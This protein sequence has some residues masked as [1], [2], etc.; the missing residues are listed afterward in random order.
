MTYLL[1]YINNF[2][3]RMLGPE[4]LHSWY[5]PLHLTFQLVEVPE[6]ITTY[7][8]CLSKVLNLFRQYIHLL[9]IIFGLCKAFLGCFRLWNTVT[10]CCLNNSF[11]NASVN[12]TFSSQLINQSTLHLSTPELPSKLPTQPTVS[13]PA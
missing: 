11:P 9:I 10:Q 3:L 1:I 8:K 12:L 2:N 5:L 13:F 7:K 4:Q 6:V